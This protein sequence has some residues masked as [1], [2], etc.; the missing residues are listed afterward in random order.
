MP[1]GETRQSGSW[2]GD[3]TNEWKT[4]K[5]PE[6]IM[7]VLAIVATVG[8][9]LYLHNKNAGPNQPG[10]QDNVS[11]LPS[12]FQQGGSGSTSGGAGGTNAPSSPVAPITPKGP[13]TVTTTPKKPISKP[14]PLYPVR[15]IIAK[16]TT[17]LA[18]TYASTNH[19]PSTHA[20]APTYTRV[21]AQRTGI[22]Q[23]RAGTPYASPYRQQAQARDVRE[24]R[25]EQAGNQQPASYGPVFSR[26]NI[27]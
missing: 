1:E 7:I 5:P 20:P 9:A 4:A 11:G 24:L 27:S 13:P 2:L 14:A 26:R 6:K 10:A 22:L 3:L 21:Q 17:T 8:I 23:Y 18:K 16:Q 25:L 12:S 15:P 19:A